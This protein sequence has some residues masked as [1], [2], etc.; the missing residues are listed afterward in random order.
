MRS[1][2]GTGSGLKRTP[3]MT[4]N[5]AVLA[6][7]QIARVRSAASVKPRSRRRRR[8][9]KRMSSRMDRRR[10]RAG[11]PRGSRA[12]RSVL[13]G[14]RVRAVAQAPGRR[15]SVAL[16]G[17]PASCSL[18]PI[19]TT[20]PAPPEAR[21]FAERARALRPFIV[22]LTLRI[23]RERPVNYS[24]DDFPG[25]GPDGMDAPG[26]EARVVRVLEGEL[27]PR[28][29]PWTTHAMVPGR[30]SLLATV[31]QGR[32]GYRHLLVLLHSDTVPSGAPSDW[33]FPPF[34]PF[35]KDGKLY[36]RGVLDD[37]GP[38][39]ASFASL[40]ILK[41]RETEIPGAFTFGAVGDE[42]VGVGVGLPY[43]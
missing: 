37:K 38:L 18:S 16:I 24:P 41:E 15:P 21:A 30:E 2:S 42:E 7:M 3:W 12:G 5:R 40:A 43:L 23:C 4:E 25:G 27:K 39:A 1:E 35:E 8:R 36:G 13:P 32:P 20:T 26:T 17:F 9:P 10:V 29:S 6:P 19:M 34:Q 22:D 33:R 28:G 11:G 31:G 14:V